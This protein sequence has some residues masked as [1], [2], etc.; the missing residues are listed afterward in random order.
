MSFSDYRITELL[1]ENHQSLWA[2]FCEDWISA[3]KSP[4]LCY[5]SLIINLS[6]WCTALRLKIISLGGYLFLSTLK[7]GSNLF[8]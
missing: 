8:R 2:I 4:A 6:G 3:S 1:I 7:N 5:L